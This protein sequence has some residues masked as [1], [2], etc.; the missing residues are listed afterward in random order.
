MPVFD[1]KGNLTGLTIATQKSLLINFQYLVQKEIL[2]LED[3]I[4]LFSTNAAHFYKLQNKGEISAGKDSDLILLDH[5]YNLTDSICMGQVMM[6]DK[7]LMA[8][9]TFS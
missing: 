3:A 5:D 9:G 2:R 8:K 6:A 7:K 4:K 1:Q